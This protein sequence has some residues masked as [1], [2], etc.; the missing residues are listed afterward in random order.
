VLRWLAVLC[1]LTLLTGL[2]T[3]GILPDPAAGLTRILFGAYAALLT[4]TL[5]IGALRW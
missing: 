1:F 2:M 3:F 4:A 5:A